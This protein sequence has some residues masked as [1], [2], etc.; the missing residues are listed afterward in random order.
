M[1]TAFSATAPTAQPVLLEKQK[2]TDEVFP[3]LLSNAWQNYHLFF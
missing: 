3:Q 1:K 2:D